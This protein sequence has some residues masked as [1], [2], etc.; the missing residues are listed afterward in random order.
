[1]KKETLQH[2]AVTG[3]I[4]LLSTIISLLMHKLI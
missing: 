4:L 2:L 1:M 3:V